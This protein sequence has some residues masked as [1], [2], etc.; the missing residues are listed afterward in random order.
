MPPVIRTR[1]GGAE[2]WIPG[3]GQAA[4]DGKGGIPVELAALEVTELQ[5]GKG[6][7]LTGQKL[8]D[9]AKAF[10]EDRDLEVVDLQQETIDRQADTPPPAANQEEK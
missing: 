5:D 4:A 7:P 2:T 3:V 8:K 1:K 10:A 6:K 9:A